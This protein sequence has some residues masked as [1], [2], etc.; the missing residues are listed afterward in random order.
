MNIG[1]AVRKLRL[2]NKFSTQKE[3]AD[4]CNI[5]IN[6]VS[7]IELGKVFPKK[8]T[9]SLLCEKLGVSESYLLLSSISEDDVIEEKRNAF[10]ALNESLMVLLK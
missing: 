1:K 3:L 10:N 8:E 2:E 7:Q 9:L 5:S 4:V 6:T